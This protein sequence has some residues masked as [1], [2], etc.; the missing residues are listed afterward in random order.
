MP[1]QFLSD[2]VDKNKAHPELWDSLLG[3]QVFG[4]TLPRNVQP[5]SKLILSIPS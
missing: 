3:I 2:L 4:A 1:L 5:G